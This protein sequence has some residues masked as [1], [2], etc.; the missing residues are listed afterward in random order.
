MSTRKKS[1]QD[2]EEY[3][4]MMEYRSTLQRLAE[5]SQSDYDKAVMTLSG[6]ALGISF[7]YLKDV[8]G[9][10]PHLY[11]YLLNL[12]WSAW[13]IS[14]VAC[15][16]SL[17]FS[18]LALRKEIAKLDEDWSQPTEGTTIWDK[19]T[20]VLNWSGGTL[21]AVGAFLMIFFV[22]LNHHEQHAA[23]NS[24]ATNPAPAI[25]TGTGG[26]SNTTSGSRP[27]NSAPATNAAPA[28]PQ[29]IQSNATPRPALT[30]APAKLPIPAATP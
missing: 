15:L 17:A 20:G 22:A 8:A 4:V 21:F 25:P 2:D 16:F 3:R 10:P 12:A 26:G 23:A 28:N 29:I 7:G 9:P 24:P 1:Q 18:G 27:H 13:T 6:G 19:L 5:Q 30:A 14:V 11:N